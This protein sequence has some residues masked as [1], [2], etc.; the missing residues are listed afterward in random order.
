MPPVREHDRTLS[1]ART[2]RCTIAGRSG[3][4]KVF[5]QMRLGPAAEH[6]E[7]TTVMIDVSTRTPCVRMSVRKY[8]KTHR[9][10]T[11]MGV[12]NGG[13]GHP[14][15]RTKGFE[16]SRNRGTVSPENGT[17]GVMPSATDEP[18]LRHWFKHTGA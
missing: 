15:R 6:G 18:F 10:A 13:R 3:A 4:T 8:L 12:T 9:T 11:S 5:A 1:T 17:R 2:K 7:E 16:G 14:I